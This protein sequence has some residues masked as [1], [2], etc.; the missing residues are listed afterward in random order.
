M[1]KELKI[2]LKEEL[3]VLSRQAYESAKNKG[4]YPKDV[5]T[6]FLLMFIIVEMSEVLQADRKGRHTAPSK[7]TRARLKWAGICLPHTRT[8]WKVR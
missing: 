5:N 1:K 7:T 6:A 3:E 2:I 4:F 8:R